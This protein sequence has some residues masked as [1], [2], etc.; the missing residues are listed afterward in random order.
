MWEIE[1]APNMMIRVSLCKKKYKGNDFERK[2]CEIWHD[3]QVDDLLCGVPIL[4]VGSV[5]KIGMWLRFLLCQ[6]G[7]YIG[8]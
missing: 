3:Y 4:F 7:C 5:G 2:N 6:C 8:L 1:L